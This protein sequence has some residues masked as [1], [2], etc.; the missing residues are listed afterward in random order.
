MET[1]RLEA[2]APGAA[3]VKRWVIV[4]IALSVLVLPAV[5]EDE[6]DKKEQKKPEP[7]RVIVAMPLA[8]AP[9]ATVKGRVRGNNLANATEIRFTNE[10][11]R[12]SV[13]IQSKAKVDVPKDA[14]AKKVG[15]SQ[16]EVEWKIPA[17]AR[18]GTQWFTVAST[19]GVSEAHPLVILPALE[20]VEEKEPNGGFKQAQPLEP[21]KVLMG[22]VKEPADVDVFRFEG[23]AGQRVRVEVTAATLGSALD[24][25]VTLYDAGGHVLASNDDA[26][27]HTDSLLK[28]KLSGDGAYF[29]SLIDAQDRGGPTSVYLLRITIEE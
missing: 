16:V 8:V 11:L 27:G 7:P 20:L 6:K 23:R 12:S 10:A 25:I 21:G 1:R 28:A 29:V 17:D 18:A 19:N 5:A 15:D 22:V 9:G 4:V 2:G 14:D 26:Q 13:V 24:S 3:V